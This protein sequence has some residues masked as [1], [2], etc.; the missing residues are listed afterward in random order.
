MQ[1]GP[2]EKTQR[3]KFQKRKKE[4]HPKKEVMPVSV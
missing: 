1:T 4:I 2:L 3:E